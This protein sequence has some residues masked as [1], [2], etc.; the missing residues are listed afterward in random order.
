MRLN[1]EI[2]PLFEKATADIFSV[3]GRSKNPDGIC[4][5]PQRCVPIFRG[6]IINS[7]FL[8]R[9]QS[10]VVTLDRSG[11]IP[12]RRTDHDSNIIPS[13]MPQPCLRAAARPSQWQQQRTTAL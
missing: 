13:H 5:V 7:P 9:S 3:S 11:T 6:W 4:L 10:W 2:V 12:V 1:F 8:S